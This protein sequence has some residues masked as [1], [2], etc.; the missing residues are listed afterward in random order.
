MNSDF[1]ISNILKEVGPRQEVMLSYDIACQYSRN[2][3]T[4]FSKLPQFLCATH[5]GIH[6]LVPKFHLPAHQQ[7]CRLELSFNYT[8]KVGR[9]DG[10]AIERLWSGL[11]YLSGSTMRMTPLGRHYIINSHL[12]YLNWKKM[13]NMGTL[14]LT[15]PSIYSQRCDRCY[16]GTATRSGNEIEVRAQS[17]I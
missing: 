5:V 2:F 7:Q 15:R 8:P 16:L 14:S 1:A 17:C 9:T 6:W 4:R 10:E 11:N 13:C 3:H 12:N